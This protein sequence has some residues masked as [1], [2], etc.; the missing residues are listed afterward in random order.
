MGA[1]AVLRTFAS[2]NMRATLVAALCTGVVSA[3]RA[4]DYSK[5]LDNAAFVYGTL[6]SVTTLLAECADYDKQ[7]ADRYNNLM[8]QYIQEN[9]DISN[10]L[11]TIMRTET[12][13][14]GYSLESLNK[15]IFDAKNLAA[16]AVQK[17]SH[18]DPKFLNTC[19]AQSEAHNKGLA[20]YRPLREKYPDQMR[21]IDQWK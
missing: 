10:R 14:S 3:V 4:Q 6:L 13:R 19:Q 8:L 11:V 7:N 2:A 1:F 17:Q 18:D 5:P 9:N 20:A 21:V 12:I 16:Q 15:T